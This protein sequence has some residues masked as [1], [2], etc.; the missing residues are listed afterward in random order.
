MDM[1]MGPVKSATLRLTPNFTTVSSI[2]VGRQI[3]PEVV[4]T[5]IMDIL[6]N[7]LGI[8]AGF[9]LQRAAVSGP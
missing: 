5:A 1:V 8:F 6:A 3:A 7:F 2:L 4:V 9:T